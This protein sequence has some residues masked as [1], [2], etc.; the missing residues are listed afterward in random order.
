MKFSFTEKQ[1]LKDTLSVIFINGTNEAGEP[2]Y[3]YC[4]V[5]GDRIEKFIQALN[6]NEP[7]TL[8]DYC[9]VL[10]SS[11]GQVNEEKHMIWREMV[12]AQYLF[13]EKGTNVLLFD[14]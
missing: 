10:I 11:T 4:G 2:F 3:A 6:A 5:R 8:N 9:T 1:K 13:S 12:N 7:F 14:S